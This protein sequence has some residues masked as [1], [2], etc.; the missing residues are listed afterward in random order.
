MSEQNRHL[1]NIATHTKN[2]WVKLCELV[3]AFVPTPFT[4]T[5]TDC[6]GAPVTAE[7]TSTVQTVPHPDFVQKVQIC[8]PSIDPEVVCLSNDGGV[9]IIKGVVE[10]DISTVPAT[11]T[12]Y[13]FDG[14]L[15]TGYEVVPCDKPMQYDY[16]KEVI[17]VDGLNYT[18]WYVWDK[19][20]D[21]LPNLVTILWLDE[22]DAVVAAPDPIL[23]NNANCKVCLPTISDAFADDLSTLLPGTSFTITKP[24]CCRIQVITSAGTITLKE[25]ETYYS[26]TDFK[27]PITITGITIVSGT[28][29]LADIHIISNFNG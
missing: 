1:A 10:F 7:A 16:E 9:T 21:T 18:K 25:K 12:I 20:G 15:A 28:C 23:I 2:M 27:C 22:N 3:D 19:F 14:S 5:S 8:T 24:E 6:D 26:T 29:S 11:K 17:C 4:V 13:L